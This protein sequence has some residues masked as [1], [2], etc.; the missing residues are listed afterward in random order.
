MSA[1]PLLEDHFRR[2]AHLE[3][4]GAITRWDE[5]AMMPVGGGGARADAMATLSAT[6]HELTGDERLGPWLADAEADNA[7]DPWQRANVREMRRIWETA[8]AL[9]T[10]LV[11]ALAGASTR[12]EQ[13]W[14]SKRAANDWNGIQPH[15]D[16]LLTLV[17]ERA[18]LLAERK[19][20][21]PYDALL[22]EYEPGLT[23]VVVGGWFD[24]LKAFLPGLVDQALSSQ[25]RETVRVPSPPFPT[26]NQRSL[27]LTFMEALGFDFAHGRLDVSHHPF[28]GGVPDDVRITTRYSEHSFLE[29]LMAVLHESGHAMYEQGLP[30]AW[31]NQPVGQTLGMAV[32]ESQSLLMEMQACRSRA[33]F[34]FAAPLMRQAFGATAGDPTW[35]ADN[36]HRLSTR[37]E[38]GLIRVDADELTYPLHVILRFDIEKALL[39]G[40]LRTADLPEAW[41]AGMQS[42]LGL[43]TRDD[44]RDGV[45]QDVHW[46]AGL[47]GYFPTYTVGAM[48]AA[49]LF[50]AAQSAVTDLPEHIARGEFRPLLGWL[51]EHV[52]GKGRLLSARELVAEATGRP[53]DPAVFRRHLEARYLAAA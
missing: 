18:Q 49:Q 39:A 42:L 50:E 4:V 11:G 7:L 31:R 43:S 46:Y 37:V 16:Q 53:L 24:D 13:A 8:R 29:A 34:E 51:R 19:R 10:E 21:T 36:L 35:S 30:A 20:L 38:R 5:A 40:E 41:D 22:D 26:E 44:Y 15:L 23:A 9:P 6:I 14:R 33:F 45:M 1:Y 32:H 3:H 47:V 12:C 52:H 17:R 25:A 48:T 2:I 27:A 28:C